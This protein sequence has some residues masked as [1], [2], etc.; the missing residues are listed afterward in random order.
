MSGPYPREIYEAFDGSDKPR[1]FVIVS[2]RELNDRYF[3]AVPFTS[4]RLDER[5]D[6]PHCVYFS[7][8]SFGLTKACVAQAE[9][10]TLLRRSDLT[11]PSEPIGTVTVAKFERIISAVGFVMDAECEPA[12]GASA[13][14]SAGHP[15]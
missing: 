1:P 3:L 2:R 14:A 15:G 13:S 5:R 12:N 8:G 10:M 9:A 6:L 11:V 7:E 4:T